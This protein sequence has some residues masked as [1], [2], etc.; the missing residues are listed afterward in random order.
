MLKA[1]HYFNLVV[2]LVQVSS[3]G[4]YV[5]LINLIPLHVLT[6]ILTG[7]FSHRVYVAYSTVYTLGT[8]LSMQIAFVGF[9]PVQSSEH[10]LV[11]FRTLVP[12]NIRSTALPSESGLTIE[13]NKHVPTAS[14]GGAPR[15]LS[16]IYIVSRHRYL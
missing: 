10:M 12:L 5:F 15:K 8:I 2:G 3:W 7:R 11:S 9:Q 14:M 4:G 6:L 16:F 13:S 1:R